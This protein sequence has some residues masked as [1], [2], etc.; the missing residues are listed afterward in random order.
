MIKIIESVLRKV[1]Q[2]KIYLQQ[3]LNDTVGPEMFKD[4]KL[5]AW[6]K[7]DIIQVSFN[8]QLSRLTYFEFLARNKLDIAPVSSLFC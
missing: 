3:S 5:L 8:D 1:G 7:L 4:F 6:D 2:E